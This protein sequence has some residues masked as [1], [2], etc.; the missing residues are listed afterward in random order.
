M[1]NTK[2]SVNGGGNRNTGNSG[3][4]GNGFNGG[5]VGGSGIVIIRN[6]R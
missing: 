3:Y 2:Y 5:S 6:K 1:G 4:G